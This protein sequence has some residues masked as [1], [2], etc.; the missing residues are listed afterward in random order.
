MAVTR[1]DGARYVPGVGFLQPDE[2]WNMLEELSGDARKVQEVLRRIEQLALR[3]TINI[4]ESPALALV[5]MDQ[6][7][8]GIDLLKRLWGVR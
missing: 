6:V 5:Q 2:H 3:A 4:K 7:N 8:E 1:K